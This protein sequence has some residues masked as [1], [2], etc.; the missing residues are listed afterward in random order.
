MAARPCAAGWMSCGFWLRVL[1]VLAA[2]VCVANSR[3]M[4]R[5]TLP[6]AFALLFA[7]FAV[8]SSLQAVPRCGI[9]ACM[10]FALF[11]ENTYKTLHEINV[12]SILVRTAISLLIGGALGHERSRK[13][14]PAGL[15]TYMLVCYGATLVMMTNEWVCQIYDYNDHVRLGAQVISGIGF[16]GA[17]SI[18][19]DKRNKITGITTAA[20]LWAAACCGLAIGIGFYTCAII[21]GIVILFVVSSGHGKNTEA[22][23]VVPLYLELQGGKTLQDFLTDIHRYELEASDV[24]LSKS[25]T[26]SETLFS[27]SLLVHTSRNMS[28]DEVIGLISQSDCIAHMEEA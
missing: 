3:R 25:K 24:K 4:A 17:G 7:N 21:S 1:E 5:K 20:C 22:A 6:A 2:G 12:I 16:L 23:I 8:T 15:R 10:D 9:M 13:N 26:A 14:H 27:F 18:I 19:L 11:F 28:H